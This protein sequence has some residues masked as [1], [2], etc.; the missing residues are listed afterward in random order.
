VKNYCISVLR[1]VWRYQS[2]NQQP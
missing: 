2:G 1:K